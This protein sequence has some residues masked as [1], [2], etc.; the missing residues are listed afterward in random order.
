MKRYISICVT[1]LLAGQLGWAQQPEGG[2]EDLPGQN[3]TVVSEIKP[4]LADARKIGLNPELPAVNDQPIKVEYDVPTRMLKVPYVAPEVRPLATRPDKV[5]Q[6]K[7][8][9]AKV[10]FGNYLTPY[11]DLYVN[12]GRSSKYDNRD[13]ETNLAARVNYIS[14]NGPLPDQQFSDLRTKL[15]GDFFINNFALHAFGGYDRHAIRFY[16]YNP[17]V[18]TLISAQDNGQTYNFM[19]G[20]LRFNN[21]EKTYYDLD[22]D[23]TFRVNYL[24]DRLNQNEINPVADFMIGKRYD[25]NLAKVRL[26][27]DHTTFTSD[28]SRQNLTIISA[29]PSYRVQNDN[30]FADLGVNVGADEDGFYVFPD[31]LFERE[32]VDELVVFHAGFTGEVLKNNYRT[33][34]DRNP[35]LNQNPLLRNSRELQVKAGVRG[36]PIRGGSYNAQVSY[37]NVNFLPLFV[38][39]SVAVNR[40]NTVYDTSTNILNLHFEVGYSFGEK[41]RVL[42][43]IDFFSYDLK[44][45]AQA[46]HLPTI[47]SSLLLRYQITDKLQAEADIFLFNRMFALSP[48]G[49][50]NQLPGVADINLGASYQVNESFHVFLD[51]NNI[52]AAN[53]QRYYN[54]PSLGLNAIGGIKM[55]F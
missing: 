23:G 22:Y 18:D 20:G 35:F 43:A 4:I 36:A 6:L 38:T 25:D 37:S 8:V 3:I 30:W 29:R 28:T 10:G 39:D 50:E 33:L 55:I 47:K 51:V 17:E 14:S 54:F 21:T 42:A 41:V 31:V 13:N 2:E 24:T 16:G 9:Y 49:I 48:E 53:Y 5:E 32:L 1:L 7:N 45:N 46:W 15:M 52:A 12:S 44:N 26:G 40:F 19:Y 34:S 11:L 27:I